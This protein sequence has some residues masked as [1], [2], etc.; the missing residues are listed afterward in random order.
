M[1]SAYSLAD[2]ASLTDAE[3]VA[4][5]EPHREWE[6][7]EFASLPG[8]GRHFVYYLH[9]ILPGVCPIMQDSACVYI[10]VTSNLRARM[11]NHS[12]KWWWRSIHP[13]LVEFDEQPSRA[14]AEIEEARAIATYNPDLN[15]SLGVGRKLSS[16]L[17]ER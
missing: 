13:D 10:G 3:V 17:V 4:L 8:P 11:R 6:P 9:A 12:Q 14:V 7:E 1:A 2:H 15:V 16:V 5:F